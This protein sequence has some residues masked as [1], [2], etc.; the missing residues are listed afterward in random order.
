MRVRTPRAFVPACVCARAWPFWWVW[1]R[2]AR[3]VVVDEQPRM[4]GELN[5]E[6]DCDIEKVVAHSSG[7]FTVRQSALRQQLERTKGG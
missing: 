6:P 2:R 5:G 3:A 4:R 1:A 7:P